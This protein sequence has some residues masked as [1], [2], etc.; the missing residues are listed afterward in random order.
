[1]DIQQA[2]DYI[3]DFSWS[4]TRLGLDRTRELLERVGNPHK[5]LKFIHVAGTNGKGSTCAMLESILRNA[6]Y[7]TGF[8]PSPFIEDF[9]ERIQVNAEYITEEALTRITEKV[10]KEADAMEDHPSQFELI[11]AI[12]MLYFEE[13]KCD[14][15]VLEVGMGGALDSTNVIDPPLAAVITNIGLDHTEFLGDTVEKIAATKAGIIKPGCHAV[16]YK[17]QPSVEEV[18]RKRCREAG[19]PLRVAK[20]FE[21]LSADLGG[22]SFI[23]DGE[24]YKLSLLGRHQLKNAAAVLET[25][26]ALKEQGYTIPLETVQ[27]G[28]ETVKWPARFEVLSDKTAKN[29]VKQGDAVQ[30]VCAETGDS[31]DVKPVF[32]LDGGHNPQCA[33]AVAAS[34]KEYVADPDKGEQVTFLIGM[35]ADKDYK[36]SLQIIRPYGAAYVCITPDSPRALSAEDLAGNIEQMLGNNCTAPYITYCSGVEEGIKK[37]VSLGRTVIAFGSLYSAGEIRRTYRRLYR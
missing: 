11:T 34:I 12:G 9:R 37:A 20:D 35:L 2:I 15:V 13:M 24:K 7:R 36:D 27:R 33:E 17:Q 18:I 32:I 3:N 22:Q 4:T 16:S 8:Y 30:T 21:E 14:V 26:E 19:V 23:Y 29:I 28:L 5:R 6:G 1:M 31:S 25:V 10:S